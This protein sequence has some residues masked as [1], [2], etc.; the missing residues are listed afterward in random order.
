M[1]ELLI[2]IK[3]YE[4]GLLKIIKKYINTSKFSN[5]DNLKKACELWYNDK[6]KCLNIYGHISYWDTSEITSMFRLFY[7][8][9]NFNEDLS[10]WN[11]SKVTDLSHMFEDCYKFNSDLN[12]WDVRK[13]EYMNNMFFNCYNF[14]SKLDKWDVRKVEDLDEMF[15]GCENFNQDL[16]NWNLENLD[17]MYEHFIFH[18]CCIKKEYM[19]ELHLVSYYTYCHINKSNYNKLFKLNLG[20][21]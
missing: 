11:T 6:E 8:F 18:N 9:T 1:D 10:R 17:E 4:I 13:V 12:E 20:I 14:N 21:N 19:P 16:S 5:S 15:W 2:K 3:N 7:G